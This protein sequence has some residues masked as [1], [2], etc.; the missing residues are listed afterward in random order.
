MSRLSHRDTYGL[1]HLSHP[2]KIAEREGFALSHTLSHVGQASQLPR[3]PGQEGQ[4]GRSGH[5]EHPMI[6]E[7]QVLRPFH[8]GEALSI[9]EAASIAGRS[10]RTLRDWC[11]RLDIGRRIGGQ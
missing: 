8:R 10:V 1:S 11:A 3:Q 9:A 5:Q 6:E 2:S 7:P 4:V